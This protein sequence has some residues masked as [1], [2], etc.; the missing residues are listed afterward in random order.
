MLIRAQLLRSGNVEENP[1]PKAHGKE[2]EAALR[3][4][5]YNV[6]G[7]NDECKL[8]HL[9]NHLYLGIRNKN[10]DYIACL[11][12]TFITHPGKIPYL[13]RGNYELTQGTGNSCG[14]VTFLSPHL[15]VLRTSTIEDRAHVLAIQRFGENEIAYIVS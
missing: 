13:W 7:L 10:S 9:I 8:R 15:N 6:R 3:V 5:S 2:H 14:C 11:Q 12:E 4:T 1:G